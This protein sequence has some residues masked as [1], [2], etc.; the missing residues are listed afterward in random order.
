METLQQVKL[1]FYE[2]FPKTNSA[3][4]Y[5]A[6]F[7]YVITLQPKGASPKQ[8]ETVSIVY[9]HKDYSICKCVTTYQ[10]QLGG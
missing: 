2:Q 3:C 8:Q 9:L 4:V 5:T 6:V 1:I 7:N 10:E